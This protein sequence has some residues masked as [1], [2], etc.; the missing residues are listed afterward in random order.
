MKFKAFSPGE[1]LCM[2]ELGLTIP[3]D[4]RES[5]RFFPGERELDGRRHA[6]RCGKI[7]TGYVSHGRC[8]LR[9]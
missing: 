5:R 6:Q 2:R 4:P 9:V 7:A 3:V 8:A 1:P